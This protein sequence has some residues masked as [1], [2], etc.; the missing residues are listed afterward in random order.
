MKQFLLKEKPDK[1]GLIRLRNE[2][3]HYLVHVRRLKP[4][5]V[6]TALLPAD[7]KDK[8]SNPQRAAITVQRIDKRTLT[9]S[10][11]SIQRMPL[12]NEKKIFG[13]SPELLPLPEFILFQ[14]LPKGTKMDLI[15]RQ[16][17]ELGIGEVVPFVSEHS[18]PKKSSGG[19]RLERWRR[20]VK[21]ACQQSGSAVLTRIHAVLDAGELF[22]YWEKLQAAKP[23]ETLSL[24]FSPPIL[25]SPLE[26]GGFH[27]YLYKKPHLLVLTVGPEGGFSA[28]ELGRFAESGFKTISLGGTVL[29]AETAALYGAAAA[30]I[31][32]MEGECWTLKLQ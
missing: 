15:V 5:S 10:A 22:T 26:Q 11:A 29:R 23:A 27:R 16:A 20:I 14:A 2:D 18:V 9:G 28:A 1:E 7:P 24:I 30:K 19:G 21:E 17:A 12:Q 4:G 3:Y 25:N 13:K 32:L 8:M 6:F 31:I